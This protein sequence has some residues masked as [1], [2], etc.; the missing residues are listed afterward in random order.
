M[1]LVRRV[2]A[3]EACLAYEKEEQG[4]LAMAVAVVVVVEALVKMRPM[5][6]FIAGRKGREKKKG[7][8]KKASGDHSQSE[9]FPLSPR[10]DKIHPHV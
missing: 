3:Y 6:F 4:V 5:L 1:L 2:L 7:E 8:K 10:N 9:L